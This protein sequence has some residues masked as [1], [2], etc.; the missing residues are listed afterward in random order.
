[1]KNRLSVLISF[2]LV[3]LLLGVLLSACGSANISVS[4]S[5]SSATSA[6]LDGQALLQERCSTCHSISQIP[7]LRGTTDQWTKLVDNMI[8]RGAQFNTQER[9][10]LIDYLAQ[11]YHQ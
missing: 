5:S 3:V 2:A 4:G 11:T 1:M 9:Q 10:T 7:Q 8:S 6:P